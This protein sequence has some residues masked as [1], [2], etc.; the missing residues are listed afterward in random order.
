MTAD[1]DRTSMASAKV[2][3]TSRGHLFH[4]RHGVDGALIAMNNDRYAFI[5][6]AEYS[7]TTDDDET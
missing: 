4:L 1:I 6:D 3:M 5:L 2:S 7:I